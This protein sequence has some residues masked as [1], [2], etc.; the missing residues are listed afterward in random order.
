M[1]IEKI[2]DEQIKF[3]L[4]KSDLE[5][6]DIQISDLAYGSEK[7]QEL[8][9][10][11]MEEAVTHCG[12]SADG[13]MPLVVE[14]VPMSDERLMI[15]VTKASSKEAIHERLDAL[16]RTRGD[17]KFVEKPII[18]EETETETVESQEDV[19]RV[20]AYVFASL[21]DV[22]S[23]AVQV[24][25]AYC[26]AGESALVK[27]QGKLYLLLDFASAETKNRPHEFEYTLSDFGQ[28]HSTSALSNVYLREHGEMLI[29]SGA[30]Q[31]L[32]M[33]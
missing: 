32:A 19:R 25:A 22:A 13:R 30:V 6:R 11:I 18:Q 2:S 12:F 26:E 14:A 16:S 1:E 20:V 24:Q 23:A 7:S 17:R 28:R 3:T 29:A 5:E 31:K 9:K 8:F 4:D 27:H 33:L 10:E 15:I 21:D